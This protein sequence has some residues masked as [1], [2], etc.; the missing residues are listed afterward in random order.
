MQIAK[1]GNSLALR[2]PANVAKSLALKA[3]DEVEIVA[4][5][6]GFEVIKD[7]SKAKALETLGRFTGRLPRNFT[8]NRDEINE[9]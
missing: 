3:G 8:F 2:I 6:T 9:R 5:P 4:S 1:W 7:E